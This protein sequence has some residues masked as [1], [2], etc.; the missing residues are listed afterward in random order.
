MNCWMTMFSLCMPP[1]M[2]QLIRLNQLPWQHDN[3]RCYTSSETVAFF[4][5]R[6]VSPYSPA[7]NLCDH[8]TSHKLIEHLRQPEEVTK[9]HSITFEAFQNDFEELEKNQKSLSSC[10][11]TTKWF[12]LVII[13]SAN[14]L[15]LFC[16]LR[17]AFCI[18]C[19][20]H[21][22]VQIFVYE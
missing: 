7:L 18:L 12:M 17:G 1:K 20:F 5:R 3:A 4:E 6:N 14:F 11:W 2:R 8:F 13:P 10:F 19:L 21:H 16:R 9:T 15:H 22:E